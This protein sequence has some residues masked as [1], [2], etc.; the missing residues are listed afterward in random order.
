M[1][2]VRSDGWQLDGGILRTIRD[3]FARVVTC[4]RA[5]VAVCPDVPLPVQQPF[6]PLVWYRPNARGPSGLGDEANLG[7]VEPFFE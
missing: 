4:E 6:H 2:R 1:V 5:G 7:R 3:G